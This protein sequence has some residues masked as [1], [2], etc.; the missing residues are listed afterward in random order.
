MFQKKI[1]ELFSNMQNLLGITDDI[2]IACVDVHSR[3][4]DEMLEKA[5]EI[6]RQSNLELYRAKCIHK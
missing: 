2:L 1:D 5:L 6:S 3:D 4:Y